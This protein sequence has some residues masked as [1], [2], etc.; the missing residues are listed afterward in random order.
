MTTIKSK[1]EILYKKHRWTLREI[2]HACCVSH[3]TVRTIL[4]PDIVRTRERKNINK[5]DVIAMYK[6]CASYQDVAGKFGVSRQYVYNIVTAVVKKR[7]K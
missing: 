3:E 2:A 4:G 1:M 7:G 6:K 5:G